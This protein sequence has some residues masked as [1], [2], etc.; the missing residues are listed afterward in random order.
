MEPGT[1]HSTAMC[2]AAAE[3][4][5]EAMRRLR[6]EHGADVNSA[7]Y[8]KR[9]PLHIAVSDEQLQMVG[10]LLQ[11]GANAE[12]LDR[13]GRSPIDCALETKN[14]A[15]LRLLEREHYATLSP[16]K[17]KGN[18]LP[19]SGDSEGMRRSQSS[20][21][22]A[23][24]FRAVQEGNAEK[25]KRSWLGGL[26]VNVTDDL[27]RTSLHVAVENGQLGVIELL[28][29]AGVNTNVVDTHGRSPI[30]IALEKQQFALAEM[31]R[32]H[33]KKKLVTRQVKSSEDEHNIALAFRAT[34]RGDL[35]SLKQL[36]PELVRPDMEDYDL[37]TLLHVASAEGHLQ[38]ARYLVDCGA[39]V[40]LLD[41]WGS[42]PLSDAVD[43]AHNELA[44]FLIA[45]HATESGFRAT[46]AVDHID[47]ATLA[48]ALEFTLRVITR[49]PW[50]MGQVHCPVLGDDDNCI[51]VTHSIW[52]KNN[53]TVQR[54]HKSEGVLSPRAAKNHP[55]DT[56]GL[57][58]DAIQKYRKVSS[59]IMIDPGQ[60]HIGNVFSGQHPEWLDL[61]AAQQAQFFL[62][63]HA[64][65]A[66]IQTVVSVPMICKMSTVAVLSW[67][68][69]RVVSEDQ[70]E[71]QRI[72]R[73]V[74][75]VMI[76]S[77]LRQELL[78]AASSNIGAGRIPRFQYCQTLDNAITANG[79]LTD[80]SILREDLN[81]CDTTPLA[82]EWGLFDMVDTLATSMSSEDHAAVVPIL[83]SLVML[84]HNGLFNGALRE[85]GHSEPHEHSEDSSLKHVIEECDGKIRTKWALLGHLKYYLQYLYAVSPT[86]ADLF[87]DVHELSNKVERYLKNQATGDDNASDDSVSSIIT[88]GMEIDEDPETSAPAEPAPAAAPDCV[89]C[90]YNVPGHIHPGR[91]PIPATPTPPKATP[92]QT[93]T[94]KSPQGEKLF[95][96]AENP[97][98]P[99][100]RQIEQLLGK[101][102]E[103]YDAFERKAELA[104]CCDG[105]KPATFTSS[106]LYDAIG[107]AHDTP[108]TRRSSSADNPRKQLL[109]V[110][111]EIM[112]D[113]SCVITREQLFAL[114][115]CL[116][117]ASSGQA[118]VLRTDLAVGYASPRIYRVFIPAGEIEGALDNL[119]NT[120]NDSSRWEHCPLLCAYYAFAVLVF[121]IHPFHD[122]N[123]RCARLLGN[124][125]AKQLGFPPLLRAADKTIQVPEFLQKAIVTMEIIRNSRRQTRQTR[126]LSTRRENSSMWF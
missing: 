58:S 20:P 38:I 76:L 11:C 86:E 65:R 111:N 92:F 4:N 5:L 87:A 114:H 57:W 50:L 53:S 118:G 68:S 104:D 116:L 80:S 3:G 49:D 54:Q 26:G 98:S 23:S 106:D 29:S 42:S 126:M 60:G 45:N 15:I 21:D 27:G 59:M 99:V 107:S 33:Q 81:V 89:L 72:Q 78:S 12:A 79:E 56:A 31:L 63:P 61:H 30:S 19:L 9:T 24:F 37:R 119:I 103:E 44:K 25:V 70:H 112:H 83:H 94:S 1:P 96:H 34:K 46:V 120:L 14:V 121:Y 109:D 115:K 52:Q 18:K 77:T 74:R 51:L 91:E 22:V 47:N 75:S 82:L 100:Y 84:L 8:D 110:I 66:G 48:A 40:N 6:E 16:F 62:L 93:K 122:G 35:E 7:D 90:K 55:I 97:K 43:F 28:L 117:P 101:L 32:A 88:D 36:V 108:V 41:R 102:E 13:W 113:T 69:D 123:G 67:Y 10:Y 124:L 71:L 125:V 85:H 39:N 64:R 17:G 2:W 73:V 105:A 95:G